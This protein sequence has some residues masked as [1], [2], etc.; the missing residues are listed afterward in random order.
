MVFAASASRDLAADCSGSF[1]I[2]SQDEAPKTRR[3]CEDRRRA[4][5]GA[6]LLIWRRFVRLAIPVP[7]GVAARE[8]RLSAQNQRF[9]AQKVI[10]RLGDHSPIT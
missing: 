7:E 6:A 9:L 8:K 10:F 1:S 2:M 3:L 4:E 5:Q